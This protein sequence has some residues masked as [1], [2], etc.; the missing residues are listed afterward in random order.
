VSFGTQQRFGQRPDKI[1]PNS[2]IIVQINHARTNQSVS[3]A[4]ILT[5]LD[6]V[7][8]SRMRNVRPNLPGKFIQAPFDR[9]IATP[10][11]TQC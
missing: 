4:L 3:V 10:R 5:E 2:V 1:N 11:P 7:E 6:A 9:K 8:S